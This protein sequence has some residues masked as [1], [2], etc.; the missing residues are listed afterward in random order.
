LAPGRGRHPIRRE[1]RFSSNA[2]AGRP[3]S[4]GLRSP[5]AGHAATTHGLLLATRGPATIGAGGPPPGQPGAGPE[6]PAG[7]RGV[8]WATGMLGPMV[9]V[10][11]TFLRYRPLAADGFSRM[12][13][14]MAA[15]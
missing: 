14:S 13:S 2:R 1:R 15:A 7:A 5:R 10:T 9:V 8:L 4:R 3:R 11:A 12:I 6:S